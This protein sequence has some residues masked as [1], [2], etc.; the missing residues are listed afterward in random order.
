[1]D[2][3]ARNRFLW[4][5]ALVLVAAL[6]FPLYRWLIDAIPPIFT[7][8]FLHDYLFLYCPMCGGTRALEELL[9]L[10]FFEA[11][12]YNLF[13]VLLCLTVLVIDVRALVRL[14]RG[15][16]R[17]YA[18][19]GKAWV[20]FAVCLVLYFVLRNYLMIAHGLDP[21]GDL[22]AFWRARLA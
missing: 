3:K 13:V 14:L 21:V 7:G 1:M 18:V 8:C 16:K 19:S 5:H 15:E 2:R 20:I 12:K 22:G 17:L 10:H 9:R 4:I 11:A 6:S